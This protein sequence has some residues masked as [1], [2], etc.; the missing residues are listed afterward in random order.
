MGDGQMVLCC[1]KRDFC[2]TRLDFVV[3]REPAGDAANGGENEKHEGC[4][5][6]C[7]LHPVCGDWH[8]GVPEKRNA[9]KAC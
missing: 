7:A 9:D 8:K 5:D 3:E 4:S 2:M 1:M 6:L